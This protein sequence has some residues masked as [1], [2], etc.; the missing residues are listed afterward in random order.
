MQK[1]ISIRKRHLFQFEIDAASKLCCPLDIASLFNSSFYIL[2]IPVINASFLFSM[3]FEPVFELFFFCL[4]VM[5]A[6]WIYFW[7]LKFKICQ[8]AF[9][10]GLCFLS[11]LEKNRCN[12]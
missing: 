12:H 6:V 11:R 4:R 10:Q 2:Q 3:I 9:L 7:N 5:V 1:I 8:F